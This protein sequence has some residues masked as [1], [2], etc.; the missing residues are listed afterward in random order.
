MYPHVVL[1]VGGTGKRTATA[2]LGTV[3]R[4][5]PGVRSDV[6]FAD[7]GGGEGSAAAVHRTFERLLS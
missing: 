5:L 3:V 6:D 4:P 7:V 2:R 1:V